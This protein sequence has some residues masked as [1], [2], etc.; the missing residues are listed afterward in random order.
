MPRSERS[1][2]PSQRQLR[3][4]EELRHALAHILE[5]G[6]IH[7]PD[8]AGRSVTVTNVTVS[9]DLRQATIYVIP[10]GGGD[11]GQLLTGLRRVRPF[12]RH[13]VAKRV[14]LRLVPD[15]IFAADVSFDQA[16]RI[17]E[18]LRRPD[19]ARDLTPAEDESEDG[20]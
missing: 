12:L 9:P 6:D 2:G 20:A 14:Q 1:R 15:F 13:Q 5:R 18:L 11:M 10:L 7:D 3:V 19:I 17:E 16:S 8:I 4:G